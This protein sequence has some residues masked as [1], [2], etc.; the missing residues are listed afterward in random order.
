MA[1]FLSIHVKLVLAAWAFPLFACFPLNANEI[2]L[3]RIPITDGF[4]A[5]VGQNG[6]GYHLSRGFIPHKHTGDDWNGDGMGDSDY[7]DPVYATATGIVTL[8]EDIKMGY[9]KTIFVIHRYKD[10]QTGKIQAVES[11]Y[12]HLKDMRVKPGQKVDRGQRIGS[13]GN[14]NG[15]Y[16]AHLHFEMRKTVGMGTKRGFSKDKINYFEPSPFIAANPPSS[17]SPLSFLAKADGLSPETKQSP[18]LKPSIDSVYA[19]PE[20]DSPVPAN[21]TTTAAVQPQKSGQVAMTNVTP[22]R[23]PKFKVGILLPGHNLGQN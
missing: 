21:T 6:K 2:L 7:G 13:I 11:V 22:T 5:P 14:G 10:Q 20:A 15:K 17:P 4:I 8:A 18:D 19:L 12:S 23:K 1:K 9:G 16:V 3:D